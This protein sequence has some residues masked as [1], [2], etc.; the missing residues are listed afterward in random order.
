[1]PEANR[2]IA[3]PGGIK[4][5]YLPTSDTIDNITQLY[6]IIRESTSAVGTFEG[7]TDTPVAL[8]TAGQIPAVNAAETALEFVDAGARDIQW[9]H[10]HAGRSR[11]CR[12]G[13]GREHRRGCL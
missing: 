4:R 13:R 6:D 2:L 9:S 8:G 5:E 3:Y 11:H 12:A 10:G 1:M 7:L